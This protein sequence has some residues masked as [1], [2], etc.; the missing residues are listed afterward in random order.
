MGKFFY[1]L[2]LILFAPSYLLA[3]PNIG[4]K[5]YNLKDGTSRDLAKFQG[6]NLW[7][8]KEKK[9]LIYFVNDEIRIFSIEKDRVNEKSLLKVQEDELKNISNIDKKDTSKEKK[10][11]EKVVLYW[12]VPLS[13]E[14]VSAFAVDKDNTLIVADNVGDLFI[15]NIVKKDSLG[16]LNLP[17]GNISSLQTL[18]DGSLIIIYKNG[19]VFFIEKKVYPIISI[20]QTLRDTYLP[21]E[22]I[23]ISGGTIKLMD[24]NE[25]G[26][27][28]SFLIGHKVL[29][30][31]NK[32]D[33]SLVKTIKDDKFV[34]C[35]CFFN[36]GLLYSILEEGKIEGTFSF[37]RHFSVLS[38]FYEKKKS[39]ISSPSGK[40]FSYITGESSIKIYNIATE[41]LVGE[42]G[43][44][45]KEI[46]DI[47][48]SYDD[49]Y[50]LI[51][52]KGNKISIYKI[53]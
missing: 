31:Y 16:R 26:N 47:K 24:D 2:L 32:P 14:G 25:N 48:F 12:N 20:F 37:H 45:V 1:I 17:K 42:I 4:L 39:V 30:I 13:V 44:N 28:L 15:F 3:Q 11:Q 53:E 8:L 9:E 21:K 43:I 38:N 36:D 6:G 29:S 7:I 51:A 18:K 41:R 49:K 50:L 33:L 19:D 22:R 40:K 10:A 52:N 23:N 46:N 27:E 35:A 5:L 34:E